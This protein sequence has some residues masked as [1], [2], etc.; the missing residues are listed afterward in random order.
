MLKNAVMM[1]ERMLKRTE[2]M[3]WKHSIKWHWYYLLNNTSIVLFEVYLDCLQIYTANA[4]AT[5]EK[6]F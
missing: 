5:T 4:T 1:R 6:R 3:N 2:V